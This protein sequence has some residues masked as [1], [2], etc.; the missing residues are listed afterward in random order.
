MIYDRTQN[1][2]ETARNLIETKVKK[3]IALSDEEVNSIERGTLTVN[4]LNRI[5]DK[6]AELSSLLKAEGYWSK[7]IENRWW[8][9]YDIFN[10]DD[11]YRIL[12]NCQVLKE[13][14]FVYSNTPQTPYA[15]YHFDN[16]NSI[17]RILFDLEKMIDDMKAKQRQCGTFQCGEENN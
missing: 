16:I 2:I 4:T 1:D 6:Q 5:E 12:D 7:N 13:A 9:Y 3:F 15:V 8:T 10:E 17:E 14:F 11:F